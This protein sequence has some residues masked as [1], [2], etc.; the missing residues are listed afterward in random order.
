[1]NPARLLRGEGAWFFLCALIVKYMQTANSFSAE[2]AVTVKKAS[3]YEL[4]FHRQT[5][6]LK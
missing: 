6:R 4:C 5:A 2:P 3:C 1:L